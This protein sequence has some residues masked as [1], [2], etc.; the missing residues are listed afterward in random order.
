MHKL[1]WYLFQNIGKLYLYSSVDYD[2]YDSIVSL[3]NMHILVWKSFLNV[4]INIWA[5]VV[6]FYWSCWN[7]H[8]HA[9]WAQDMIQWCSS[10]CLSCI[11]FAWFVFCPH[12][13]VFPGYS[14]LIVCWHTGNCAGL[15]IRSR[16][17]MCNAYTYADVY[18]V[19]FGSHQE[20]PECA[21]AF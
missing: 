5:C 12:L 3:K 1:F 18:P 4:F 2:T 6:I 13:M 11:W 15:R 14:L 8:T 7:M 10:Y 9:I 21:L 20:I 16:S 17:S 19:N